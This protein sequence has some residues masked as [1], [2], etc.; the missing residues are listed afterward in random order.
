MSL[1]EGYLN[2]ILV[3]IDSFSASMFDSVFNWGLYLI[4]A[5]LGFV[6]AASLLLIL[7]V[8]STHYLG[9]Y[10]CRTSVHLGWVTYGA[11][12]LGI[13]ILCF[14]FFSLGG[15]SY[16]FCEFYGSL[17]KNDSSFNKFAGAT[18]PNEFNRFF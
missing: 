18:G 11:T 9:L 6:L 13:V 5:I 2:S 4:Q 1:N 15:I 3:S 8:I 7:G 16:Q 10:S 17:I 12:Y 14:I